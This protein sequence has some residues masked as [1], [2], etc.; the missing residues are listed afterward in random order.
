MQRKNHLPDFKINPDFGISQGD[1]DIQIG[2]E[3]IGPW[4]PIDTIL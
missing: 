2:S 4:N 3:F 1:F